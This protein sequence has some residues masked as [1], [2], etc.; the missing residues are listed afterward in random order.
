MSRRILITGILKY[1]DRIL[2]IKG[3]I[4]ELII[5]NRYLVNL[6]SIKKFIRKTENEVKT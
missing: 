5:A 1:T 2:F 4:L 6:E 3:A